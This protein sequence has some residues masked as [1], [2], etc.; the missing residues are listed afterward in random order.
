MAAAAEGGGGHREIVAAARADADLEAAV[1][2]LLEDGRGYTLQ[3]VDRGGEA[4]FVAGCRRFTYDQ[5]LAHWS[6]LRHS[7]RAAARKLKLVGARGNNLKDVTAEIP[8]GLFTCITGV[9]GGGKST[10]VVDTLYKAIAKRL[11]GVWV[12][13]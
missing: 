6:P 10:L 7:D 4:M 12:C 9:S 1:P 11:N 5:A 13:N 2:L 8:L 3:A